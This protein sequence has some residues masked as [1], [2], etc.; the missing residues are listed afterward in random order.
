MVALFT[1]LLFAFGILPIAQLEQNGSQEKR[2]V[3]TAQDDAESQDKENAYKPTAATKKVVDDLI[4]EAESKK[5]QWGDAPAEKRAYWDFELKEAIALSI[6]ERLKTLQAGEL[7]DVPQTVNELQGLSARLQPLM[8]PTESTY[9]VVAKIAAASWPVVLAGYPSQFNDVLV[10]LTQPY[11]AIIVSDKL[12]EQGRPTE[13]LGW[14]VQA[15][16]AIALARAG[17]I[18][19][20]LKGNQKLMQKI[21]INLQKGR[22]PNQQTEFLGAARSQKSL[23]MQSQ[24]QKALILAIARKTADSVDASAAAGQ[25]EIEN[26][27]QADQPAIQALLHALLK[28]QTGEAH[29]R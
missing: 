13:P 11:A 1:G 6:C 16:H 17:K 8:T 14:D 4:K 21:E 22:L 23:L 27:T 5:P 9:N 12:A 15:A 29:L 7:K 19:E 24:L 18:E 26:P 2:N 10:D 3:R 20:S 28:A 25:V